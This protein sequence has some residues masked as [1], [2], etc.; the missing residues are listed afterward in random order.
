MSD[1]YTAWVPFSPESGTPLWHLP[2]LG[3]WG[4]TLYYHPDGN[5]YD[6]TE[7]GY[8]STSAANPSRA[9][10][11]KV[12]ASPVPGAL[13]GGGDPEAHSVA[14]STEGAHAATRTRLRRLLL[15]KLGQ[16]LWRGLD[17][18]RGRKEYSVRGV[19]VPYAGAHGCRIATAYPHET[20]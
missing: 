15:R 11:A 5:I 18:F 6:G 3:L 14:T 1:R 20:G 2:A 13:S 16:T 7:P 12:R 9:G 17:S 8:A 4:E 19:S 10:I